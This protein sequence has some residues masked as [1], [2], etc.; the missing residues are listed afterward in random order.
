M[1]L[2]RASV[3]EFTAVACCCARCNVIRSPPSSLPPMA[4]LSLPAL[5]AL[6]VCSDCGGPLSSVKPYTSRSVRV[7]LTPLLMPAIAQTRLA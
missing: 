5:S 2:L 1:N 6:L 3:Q 4:D 7:F